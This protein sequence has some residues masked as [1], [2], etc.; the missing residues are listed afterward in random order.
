MMWV[1]IA[2]GMIENM[3]FTRQHIVYWCGGNHFFLDWSDT[4]CSEKEGG[5]FFTETDWEKAIQRANVIHNEERG[6]EWVQKGGIRRFY[7][8]H[9]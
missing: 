1:E 4:T 7:E 8:Y 6:Q 2:N 3:A 9:L 5:Y